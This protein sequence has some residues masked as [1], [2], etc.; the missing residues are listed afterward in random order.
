MLLQSELVN[1]YPPF[2]RQLLSIEKR[3]P[4]ILEER[5]RK[6]GHGFRIVG[7]QRY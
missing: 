4:S 1:N 3:D 6:P 7:G 5:P 2:W